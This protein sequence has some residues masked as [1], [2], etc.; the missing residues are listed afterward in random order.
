[1]PLEAAAREEID[2]ALV[3]SGWLVQ[4]LA[5]MNLYAGPGV[6]VREVPLAPG[7]G[8]ADYL[9]Y[10]DCQAV[11]VVEAKRVGETLT[12]VEIQSEKYGAGL[13]A[14]IPAP[15]RPLPFLYQSTG[16]ETRFTNRLDPVP[17]S[18]EVFA[19]HRPETLAAWATAEPLWLP[20]AGGAPDPRSERPATLRAR[21]TAMPGVEP[22]GLWPAQLDTVRHLEASLAAGRPRALVQMATGS[23]KTIAAVASIYRLL[24]FGGA[25]RVLFLVDRANLGRQALKEFQSYRTPDDGRLFTELYNVQRLTANRVDP[26]ANVVIGTVQRLYSML[27][28]EPTMAEEAD[29]LDADTA[30]DAVALTGDAGTGG[31]LAALR[32]DPIP[33]A[34]NPDLPVEL[35][36]VVFVD[37]C[38]R[39]IY[40]LWRQVVEYWD[41]FLVG[42]TATPSK[43]TYGFFDANV[44]QE[45]GHE[46][47]VADGVNVDFDVYR[48]RTEITERGS[49]VE[50]G[51]IVDRRDRETRRRRWEQ[52]DEPLVYDAAALDRDV[53][54]P[55]QIR[56]VV[57]AFRDRFL[58]EVFPERTHV[59]KTLVFAKDDS[60]ADDL[61][62][63]LRDELSLGN[64]AVQ[65]ITYK[66]GTARIVERVPG[67]DGAEVERVTY[68]SSGVRPEDLLQSFRNSYH[69][70]IAVTVDMIATGTDVKP[71]EVL[72]FMRTVRSR[73]LFEQ[74]KG[75]GVRVVS[76]DDLR[77]VTPDAAAKTRY[78]IVDCVGVCEEPMADTRPMDVQ[79]TVSLERLL[80]AV[81]MGNVDPEVASTLASRLV[82][83]DARLG[84]DE[85]ASVA[86][87]TGGPTLRDLAHGIVDAL[88]PDR[89][90]AAARE[91]A[92]AA[93]GARVA[94][95]GW[96]PGEAAV[97]RARAALLRAALAPL[98]GDPQLRERLLDLKRAKEQ[99]IDTASADTLLG[100][101]LSPEARDRALG[102]TTSFEAFLTEHRDELSALRL[103]YGS[104]GP[105]QARLTRAAVEELRRALLDRQPPL[106][107]DAVWR[108]YET[109]D[110]SRVRGGPARLL[111]D[112]VA[113]VRFATHRDDALAPLPSVA[114]A[115]L[116]TWLARMEA[117]G[118]RFTDE[119]R[120]WLAM[121]VD[122]VAAD[123]EIEA[124]DFD[125]PPFT[126]RGG[127]AGAHRVFGT[128]LPRVL[129]EI[130]EVIAA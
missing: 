70:R 54:A 127:L 33:V 82:R 120:V 90:R 109:L 128:E 21:L 114:R 28:G 34:Y 22:G 53:V 5:A 85:R 29:E 19:F 8:V 52:L 91:A 74:M 30:L 49:A 14:G 121:M 41:A 51:Q 117:G 23:G 111:T 115:R 98:A 88:D 108:A 24:K 56:T 17:R 61:V 103:L 9:L 104:R 48:I 67:P 64:D 18:R 78:V 55:D 81:A 112:V 106:A 113:L 25:K 126:Q 94:E 102:L 37:E 31:G 40:T 118:R 116:D 50:A 68:K 79:P 38:H 39:S 12:G 93:P 44:V 92:A 84:R 10:A 47:A 36:D 123:V 77:A 35:F 7:H 75:R 107:L 110:R 65:K 27:R 11:G 71:L 57:R 32:R 76:P 62:K 105:G 129:E 58:P 130:G 95:P 83:L 45:Y 42:L 26:V 99:T 125:D 87:T 3:A 89:Q 13:P 59:P 15:V 4:D 69:P 122:H 46:H 119:Q 73:T 60:H 124:E 86:A 6:A 101:G 1:M 43:L 72:W 66:T 100:A 97:A 20:L 16:V 80:Q 63:I 96:E 2:R